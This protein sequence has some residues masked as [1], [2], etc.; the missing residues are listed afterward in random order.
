MPTMS[1]NAIDLE[2]LN[3]LTGEDR[4]LQRSLFDIYF[5]DLEERLGALLAALDAGSAED[6]RK[7]AHFLKGASAQLGCT[8]FAEILHRMETAAREGRVA[9]AVADREALP[10]AVA[11]VREHA[12]KL[13][14]A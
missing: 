8:P 1:Q 3:M 10:E 4:E 12:A 6:I 2:A 13:G 11:A 14:L 7:H 9:D 5:S